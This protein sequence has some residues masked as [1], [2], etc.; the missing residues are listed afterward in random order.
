MPVDF[1][2]GGHSS[3]QSVADKLMSVNFDVGA[4]RPWAGK[5]GRSYIS[6]NRGNTV[7]N[8]AVGN[9]NTTLRKDDWKMLDKAVLKAAMARLRVVS[10]LRAAGLTFTIPNGMGKTV[11]EYEKMSD[12]NDAT[13]SMDGLRIGPND[14][15]EFTT[16]LLPLPIIHK[17]FNFSAR[18]IEASRNGGS[19]L[20]TTMAEMAG[21]KVAEMAEKL[22]LGKLSDYTY[23]DGTIQ[24]MTNF[25]SALTQV[26]TAPDST[27]WVAS[28]LL[29]E[30]LTM[31]ESA[32]AAHHYGPYMLYFS[33][34]WDKYLDNDF[35]TNYP[36][37]TVRN[38]IKEIDGVTDVRTADFLEDWDVVM[39][40]LSPETIRIV[41]GMGLVTLEWDS[42]GGLL[43]NYKVMTIIV[44]QVRA[45]IN[46]NTGIVY[47]EA[48]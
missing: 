43:K 19:P 10:D 22:T 45:D 31:K 5:D 2:Y 37:K 44:P 3:N 40:E 9:A 26:M 12:I 41:V 21:R 32:K 15:P 46:N 13:I 4:L 39:I 7:R 18:Q 6:V 11:L 16:G 23:A 30:V 35:N 42:N 20:D 24:G 27:D 14:R 48:A 28:V 17:D 38:R 1:I 29:D 36:N 8:I 47:G 25:D 34:S 33:S